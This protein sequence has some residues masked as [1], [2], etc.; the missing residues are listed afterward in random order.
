MNEQDLRNKLAT[1][2][3]GKKSLSQQL[4]DKIMPH[5]LAFEQVMPKSMSADRFL[6]LVNRAVM[7]SPDLQNASLPSILGC[8]MSAAMLGLEPNTPL[9][10]A[11][12]LP[13]KSKDGLQAQFILGYRGMLELAYRNPNIESIHADIVKKGDVFEWQQGT[14]ALLKHTYSLEIERG[15]TLGAY[16]SC[17]IKNAGTAFVV[18]TKNEIDTVK[19]SSKSASS[20]YSPW[21][22]HYDEMA[23]KT[24]IRRLFKLIPSSIEIAEHLDLDGA[25]ITMPDVEF[26]QEISV[27]VVDEF[28]DE[29]Q[30]A[31]KS[32]IF[33]K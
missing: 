17:K 20:A 31:E 15:A 16:A 25:S 7:A 23:K 6:R 21:S 27:E 2:S 33:T 10:T 13:F 8:A 4:M 28:Q 11:Y 19:R 3:E 18:I 24:A 29:N 22:T 14:D 12:I 9:G 1:Q 5:K 26:P 32:E 30:T